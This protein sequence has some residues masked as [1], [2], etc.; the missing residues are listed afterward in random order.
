MRISH[1]PPRKIVPQKNKNKKKKVNVRHPH[2]PTVVRSI[3]R[4]SYV[5]PWRT[6]VMFKAAA[7]FPT[8]LLK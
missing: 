2:K 1:L 8:S 3:N 6:R 5:R 7:V 4:L